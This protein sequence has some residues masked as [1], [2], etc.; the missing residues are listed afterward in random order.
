MENIENYMSL[1]EIKAYVE[2]SDSN[3]Y[4]ELPKISA[5]LIEKLRKKPRKR[6]IEGYDPSDLAGHLGRCYIFPDS[7]KIKNLL[8]LYK[9]EGRKDR[10]EMISAKGRPLK[11]KY[12][13]LI[14]FI[15]PEKVP[16]ALSLVTD[17]DTPK[18]R[19]KLTRFINKLENRNEPGRGKSLLTS[20]TKDT[21]FDKS[22]GFVS[23]TLEGIESTRRII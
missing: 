14:T 12:I 15:S 16:E 11:G 23:P 19:S 22:L 20:F 1:P 10:Y 18:N 9:K 3:D 8:L 13:R 4:S 6:V 2:D 5:E 21:Q 7:E 17:F